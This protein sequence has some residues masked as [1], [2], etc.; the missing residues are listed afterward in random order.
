MTHQQAAGLTAVDIVY[1]ALGRVSELDDMASIGTRRTTFSY[2]PLGRLRQVTDP[3]GRT[4]VYTYDAAGRLQELTLPD[5]QVATFQNGAESQLSSLTPPGRPAYR[6]EYNAVGLL[7]NYVPPV[8]NGLDESLHYAYDADQNLSRV[9][10]P[11][12]QVVRLSLG[13][14]G[15]GG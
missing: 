8:V 7:T 11:D 2:D 15:Q 10:L 1:D 12:G 4:N 9:E 6:F 3:L 13:P 5:G 14:G